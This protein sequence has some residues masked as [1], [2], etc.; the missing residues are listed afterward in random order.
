[1]DVLQESE[2]QMARNKVKNRA[3]ESVTSQRISS[4][5]ASSSGGGKRGGC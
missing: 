5:I 1:M 2:E 4:A 3:G